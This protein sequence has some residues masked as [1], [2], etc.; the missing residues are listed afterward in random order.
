MLLV[1]S[2]VKIS[3]FLGCLLLGMRIHTLFIMQVLAPGSI[4]KDLSNLV[5]FGW[6][7]ICWTDTC[8]LGLPASFRTCSTFSPRAF[9]LWYFCLQSVLAVVCNT[10]SHLVLVKSLVPRVH[11]RRIIPDLGLRYIAVE[12]HFSGLCEDVC[13]LCMLWFSASGSF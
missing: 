4:I 2:D 8:W 7:D 12:S 1:G 9:M 13:Q 11:Q 3:C 5:D 6:T 10:G